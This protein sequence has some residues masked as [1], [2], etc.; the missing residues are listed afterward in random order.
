MNIRS[1]YTAVRSELRPLTSLILQLMHELVLRRIR[2]DP[3]TL[4]GRR[5][6]TTSAFVMRELLVTIT[7]VEVGR[8]WSAELSQCDHTLTGTQLGNVAVTLSA[9]RLG[10]FVERR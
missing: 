10:I 9:A 8:G 4:I 2:V 1:V 5:R 3:R 7:V 6:L